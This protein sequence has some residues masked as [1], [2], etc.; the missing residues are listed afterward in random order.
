MTT[1][2]EW[3][4]IIDQINNQL[5]L[6]LELAPYP[7][8][9]VYEVVIYGIAIDR[10]TLEYGFL[11]I[12]F[13]VPFPINVADVF[14]VI[15]EQGWRLQRREAGIN[16]VDVT[17]MKIGRMPRELP[18]GQELRSNWKEYVLDELF[19]MPR[20]K[21]KSGYYYRQRSGISEAEYKKQRR[22]K[23]QERT[24]K[25]QESLDRYGME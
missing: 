3:Q 15:E 9:D 2:E 23:M 14:Q 10:D 12:T 7:S 24:K 11:E 16:R 25:I 6:N 8:E 18:P 19:A 1:E 21:H 13:Y 4:L 17:E 5:V 22:E 20:L